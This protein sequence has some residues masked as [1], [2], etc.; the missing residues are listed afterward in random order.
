MHDTEI[1]A[2]STEDDGLSAARWCP[3]A[4]R[5]MIKAKLED[6]RLSIETDNHTRIDRALSKLQ[7]YKYDGSR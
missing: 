7:L 2:V 4:D 5:A 1:V 3:A 6:W